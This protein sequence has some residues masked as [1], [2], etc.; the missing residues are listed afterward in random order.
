MKVRPRS[1]TLV[2]VLLASTLPA[3]PADAL[4]RYVANNGVDSAACGTLT[5]PCRSITKAI[6]GAAA[7][8]TIV[9]GPGRY[10]DIDEDRQSTT[11][12]DETP[13]ASCVC[14]LEI[15]KTVTVA[16]SAGA[17]ATVISYVGGGTAIRIT[18]DAVKLGQ[19][20]K[21]FT[22]RSTGA[23]VSVHALGVTVQDN[24]VF[25]AD[26][27]VIA[28]GP[29]G[30]AVVGNVISD[31]TIG[32]VVEGGAGHAFTDNVIEGNGTGI[33]LLSTFDVLISG[34]HLVN[35]VTHG[36][37]VQSDLTTI[38]RNVLSGT[39]ESGVV[40]RSSSDLTVLASNNFLNNG[41]G[42]G[43][44]NCGLKVQTSSDVNAERNYWG[45]AQGPGADP[46]DAVC[47]TGGA[48]VDTVPFLTK[49]VG[50]TTQT[51]R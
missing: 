8:D 1:V 49:A 12:G 36:V 6:A 20:D 25:A 29:S 14:G 18:A 10:G 3:A 2:V 28:S 46:G 23:G 24:R 9:V 50:I 51:G 7:G 35:N 11:P 37:D 13:A 17:G 41:G 16:S 40:V 34:N 19:L 26:V 5:A 22:I 21:G 31:A 43:G 15:D 39:G 30:L 38:T 4:L 33:R 47:N 32:L 44:G 27:G 42:P 45:G 48:A